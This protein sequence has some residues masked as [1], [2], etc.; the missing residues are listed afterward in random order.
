[1]PVRFCK[2]GVVLAFLMLGATTGCERARETVAGPSSL[3]AS[4]RMESTFGFEPAMLRPESIPDSS[5]GPQPRFATRIV[6][7]VNG[8]GV[9][10]RGLK[11][12]FTDR[13]GVNG[14]PRVIP[15]PGPSPLSVPA[16]AIPPLSPIPTPG[17][18]PLPTTSAIPIPGG[19]PV[20]GLMV[21][22]GSARRLAFFLR[23]DCGVEPRGTVFID[24]EVTESDGATRS[25]AFRVA[26]GF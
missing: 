10:V 11:F 16:S 5:C 12:R 8:D 25:P 17:V 15:I 20:N 24:A 6:V 23:F 18:A 3:S 4:L 1:M 14:L 19:S 26:L 13:L 22:A 7:I 21:P 2:Y 9:I